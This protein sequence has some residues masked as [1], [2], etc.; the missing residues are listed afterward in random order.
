MRIHAELTNIFFLTTRNNFVRT[1]TS[2][3]RAGT[4][5]IP[6]FGSTPHGEIPDFGQKG[7]PSAFDKTTGTVTP[8]GNKP[9]DGLAHTI[10]STYGITSD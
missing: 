6:S 9:Y 1:D 7:H 10:S 3:A 4:S 5:V 8:L 2:G